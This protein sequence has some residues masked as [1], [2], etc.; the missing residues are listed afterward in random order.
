MNNVCNLCPR[1]CN[2]N[3]TSSL[4]YCKSTSTLRVARASLHF[5]EEPIISGIHGSG[6]IFFSG[7][8]LRCLYCQNYTISHENFGKDI[9]I[10]KLID[11]FKS[12]EN[13]GAHN[14]NLV[15]PTHYIDLIIK[16]LSLYK[17]S[18]PIVYN[19]NGYDSVDTLIKIAP[20]IDIYLVDFK[21]YSSSLSG[22]LSSAFDYSKV[23]IPA[24]TQMRINQP[25]DIIIDGI[26]Q[27]GMIIRHLVL[28]NHIDD[29]MKIFDT[30]SNMFE[31]NSIIIS[32]MCQYTPMYKA[33]KHPDI[34]RTL[35][36]L[37]YKI[38]K[39]HL[40]KLGFTNGYFQ[41]MT[42]AD[43]SFTPAFDLTGVI[44]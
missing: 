38:V 6:T 24:I 21:Y 30:L 23:V 11:I 26:L 16:A 1:H 32:L 35:K 33:L 4:G 43:S 8:N 41:D 31:P 19:S 36:P 44:D 34:S 18:I 37:E 42:S 14:I 39:S 3:R 22:R 29:S 15:T 12:L 20:F 27:K 2:V 7:C 5:D 28:P 25:K 40:L 17:P 9:T 10:S 13:Q